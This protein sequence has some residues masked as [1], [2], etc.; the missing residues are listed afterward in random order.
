[1]MDPDYDLFAAIV[2]EGGL[3]AAG[4]RLRISPAMVSKRL[5]RLEERLGTRLI[6]RTT[7]RLALTAAGERLHDDLREIMTALEAA[8]RRVSGACEEASGTIR[9]TAPT[10]FGRMHVAPWLGRF[11]DEHPRVALHIDLSDDYADLLASRADLAIRITVDPGP[12]LAARRLATNRRIVC[13]APAYL[14]RFGV[15]RDIADLRKHRLL[16]A[17]GQLPWRLIGP[18]GPVAVDGVSHVGTNSSEVVREL[19]MAGAGVAL[20]SLWDIS[21]ALALGQVRQILPRF[22][23]SADVGLFAVHLPQPHPPL[24]LSAFIDFLAGLYQPAPPWERTAIAPA[25]QDF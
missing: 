3:A 21:E 19:A 20:R 4:R 13:A 12:G 24:A 10:S 23:G 25:A 16:A 2:E 18:D 15:P 8:E 1:M 11:M 7:R 22:E 5:V 14:E 17:E 6:H 9:I